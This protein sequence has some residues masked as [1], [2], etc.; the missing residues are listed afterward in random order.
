MSPGS[1]VLGSPRPAHS[2]WPAP[3]VERPK[4]A[5]G[6]VVLPISHWSQGRGSQ[7]SPIKT[8]RD[9]WGRL[10]LVRADWLP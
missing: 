9:Y 10:S 3:A 5:G 4:H 2:L 8:I 7:G 1:D 6:D